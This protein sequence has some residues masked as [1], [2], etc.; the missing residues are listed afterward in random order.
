MKDVEFVSQL[1]L[2]IEEGPKGYSSDELDK[3]FNDRESDWEKENEVVKRFETILNQL[4]DL[5]K[6]DDR[7]EISKSRLKNQA[8]FYSIFGAF[9]Q[10]ISENFQFIHKDIIKNLKSF[11]STVENEEERK[12]NKDAEKY[13]EHTR[14]ASNRTTARKE[15]QEILAQVIK[16]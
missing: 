12:N 2:L 3:E 5:V 11:L 10:L 9:T 1:F 15:R 6:N 4:T 13:F 7:D 16:K 14:T 8:D